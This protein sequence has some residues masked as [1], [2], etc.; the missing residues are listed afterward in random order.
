MIPIFSSIFWGK[1]TN[2]EYNYGK[3]DLFFWFYF[4]ILSIFV[5]MVKKI[6]KIEV[7]FMSKIWRINKKNFLNN[8]FKIK[9]KLKFIWNFFI[10]KI[11]IIQIIF[12]IISPINQLYIFSWFYLFNKN[13]QIK[14]IKSQRII[15][16]W[17]FLLWIFLVLS[18]GIWKFM[19]NWKIRIIGIIC[20]MVK[21]NSQFWNHIFKF[22]TYF[23]VTIF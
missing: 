2:F 4:A 13:D 22:L 3:N 14:K 19:K 7:F 18:W 8:W 6:W 20:F 15:L 17:F 11:K 21:F 12:I 1:Y 23:F 5:Q 9:K 16:F 10:N